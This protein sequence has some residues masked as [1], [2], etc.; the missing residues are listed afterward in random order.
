MLILQRKQKREHLISLSALTINFPYC[1]ISI[2]I[3]SYPIDTSKYILIICNKEIVAQIIY[4]TLAVAYSKKMPQFGLKFDHMNNAV[5][6]YICVLLI[7]QVQTHFKMDEELDIPH[8]ENQF[9]YYNKDDKDLVDTNLHRET[10]ILHGNLK[11]NG[12]SVAHIEDPPD[13]DETEE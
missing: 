3:P 6:N 9:S 1:A 7:H 5:A 12:A 10:N 4:A 13:S 8:K 11:H 2:G